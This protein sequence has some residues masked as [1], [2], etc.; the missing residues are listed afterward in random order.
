MTQAFEPDTCIAAT[1][2]WLTRAV[3]GLNLCP[4][5]A[6][7]FRAG[8]VHFVA[9]GA[10][11]EEELLKALAAEMLELVRLPAEERETTL[12]VHPRVMGDFLEFNDFLQNAED[13]VTELGLDGV[14]QVASFH[15]QYQFAGTE[16][17]D[18]GNYSN[19]SPYPTLH[20]LRE[21]SVERA[22]EAM[23]DT[24][25]IFEDNIET[26]ER[27]GHAGWRALWGNGKH[28]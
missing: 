11:N 7:P 10:Q 9:S 22:V 20:L 8:T 28:K 19:R 1:R 24:D 27:L 23:P 3:L 5:A 26:L 12:L 21:E 14:L 6:A 15:P 18:I 4:F 13:L 2:T 16:A 17:D 25:K